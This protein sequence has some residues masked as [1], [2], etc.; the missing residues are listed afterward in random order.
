MKI[1]VLISTIFFTNL[2]TPVHDVPVATFHITATDAVV[3]LDITFDLEDFSESLD[4]KTTEVNLK[5]VQAYL[6][7]NTNF[8]FNDQAANF[9]I[10]EV[11]ILRDHHIKAKGTFGRLEKNIKTVKVENTCLNNVA[12]H[13]NVIQID[14]NDQSKDYRMHKKRTVISLVY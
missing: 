10:T 12:R 9:K 7:E 13:S 5:N 1:L 2:F 14:L 4:I 3:N 6:D 11:K 8:Y